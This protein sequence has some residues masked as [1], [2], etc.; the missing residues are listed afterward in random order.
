MWPQD[1]APGF[2]RPD[3]SAVK[4]ANFAFIGEALLLSE[5]D[6][7]P[8]T[9]TLRE[10]PPPLAAFKIGEC[11]TQACHAYAWPEGTPP[12]PGLRAV[13]LRDAFSL[14]AAERWG[15]AARARQMLRWD[16]ASR[17][18]GTCGTPTTALQ[19]EPAKECPACGAR[20]YPRIA[21]AVMALVRRGDA[22]LLARSP[23]FRAGMYSALAGF[24]E[25]GE[26]VE[27]C[28]HREVF[29]ESGIRI[30]NL[31][32]FASQPWPFPYSLMLAFH[33]DYAG[34]EIRPQPG[35][36]EDARWFGLEALPEL[37]APVSIASRLIQAGIAEIRQEK[38][39]PVAMACFDPRNNGL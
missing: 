20:D 25:A 5:T 9:D 2:D 29:E 37:P 32:W 8:G 1:F 6:A 33:A 16:L 36:I 30:T 26:T 3:D 19:G 4:A 11:G 17:Y 27:D 13:G 39:D 35:E 24:V 12:P 23:H 15:V 18:C 14:Q 7:L 31:R 21:P 34:G 10:L 38:G 22:L 28:L